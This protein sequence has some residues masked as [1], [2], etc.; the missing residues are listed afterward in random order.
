MVV[1]DTEQAFVRLGMAEKIAAA[2][3]TKSRHIS[4][5]EPGEIS[6]LARGKK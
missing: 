1:I 6:A 4:Q 5:L 2:A 3:G